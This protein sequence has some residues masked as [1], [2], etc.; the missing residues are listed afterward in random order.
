[1]SQLLTVAEVAER[2]RVSR[3]TVKRLVHAG[4]LV[5]YHVGRQIRVSA[6]IL[7]AYLEASLIGATTT[8]PR[9]DEEWNE[10]R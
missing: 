6:A 2:L 4:D 9:R 8:N 3:A 10:T 1:M 5:G 7:D